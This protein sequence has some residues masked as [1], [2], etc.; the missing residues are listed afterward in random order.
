MIA[1]FLGG[2]AKGMPQGTAQPTRASSAGSH[3]AQAKLTFGL[4]GIFKDSLPAP[5]FATRDEQLGNLKE[6]ESRLQRY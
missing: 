4:A 2:W 5:T 1:T 6:M 3:D